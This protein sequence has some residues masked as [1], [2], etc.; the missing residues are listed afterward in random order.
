MSEWDAVFSKPERRKS[1]W[2]RQFVHHYKLAV[3]SSAAIGRV[4]GS[5]DAMAE[6]AADE[7]WGQRPFSRAGHLGR[8]RIEDPRLIARKAG[9]EDAETMR[10]IAC[11]MLSF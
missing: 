5:L 3:I 4:P 7:A 9:S 8:V 11:Q 1:D 10:P 2:V 6:R